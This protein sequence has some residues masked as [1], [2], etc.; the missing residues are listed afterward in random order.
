MTHA[1]FWVTPHK[2]SNAVYVRS[3]DSVSAAAK[4]CQVVKANGLCMGALRKVCH[5]M[6]PSGY[7]LATTTMNSK[8][9]VFTEHSKLHI[10]EQTTFLLLFCAQLSADGK[11]RSERSEFTYTHGRICKKLKHAAFGRERYSKVESRWFAKYLRYI[12]NRLMST[13]ASI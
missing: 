4:R 12:S 1:Y 5:A 2:I 13:G 3:H 11:T 8:R 7:G 6:W 10:W 9:S